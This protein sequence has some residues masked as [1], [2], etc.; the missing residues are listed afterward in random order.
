MK[1]G[2]FTLL[3]L[4]LFSVTAQAQDDL[5]ALKEKAAA[6]QKESNELNQKKKALDQE[7]R[8]IRGKIKIVESKPKIEEVVAKMVAVKPKKERKLLVYSRTTGFRHSSIE[9]GAAV[10]KALGQKTG[11]FSVTATEDPSIFTEEKLSQFDAVLMLSTTGKPIPDKGKSAF[12]KFLAKRKGLV[13][14]HAATDCHREWK[15]YLDAIGGL[16]DGHP[17]NAGSLVTLYNEDPTHPCCKNVPQGF[18]IKDEIYQYKKDNHFTRDKLRILLS[19]D[20]AGPKMKRGGMKRQDNDYAVSWVREYSNSRVFYTNLGHN[21]STFLDPVA[22]QHMLAGIQYAMGDIEAD[23]TPSAKIGKK[24][25]PLPE[26][27]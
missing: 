1:L 19:L 5:K 22:L 3:L 2:I 17:W 18:Q 24:P 10:F 4:L 21:E 8:K 9:L 20:L 23:A 26:G 15:N 14:I 27:F 11:A 25:K 16:F 12:E 7:L 13:G 6:M